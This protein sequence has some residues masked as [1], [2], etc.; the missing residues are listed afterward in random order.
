[1]L[2]KKIRHIMLDRGI[3]LTQLAERLKEMYGK[4]QTVQNLSQKF[5]RDNFAESEMREI[6]EALGYRL[7]INFVE[8]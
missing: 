5:T 3:N 7:E 2:A 6:A 8:K 1:M 4:E